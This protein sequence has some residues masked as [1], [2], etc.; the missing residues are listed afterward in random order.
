[1]IEVDEM[2]AI[3]YLAHRLSLNSGKRG[4]QVG[5]TPVSSEDAQSY[6]AGERQDTQTAVRHTLT[7]NPW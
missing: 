5:V 6:D 2:P 3:S 7:K 1:M 4:V